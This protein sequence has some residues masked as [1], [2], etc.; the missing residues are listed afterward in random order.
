MCKYKH[1][2]N[3]AS[4]VKGCNLY[5]YD[6]HPGRSTKSAHSGNT[7]CDAVTLRREIAECI[8]KVG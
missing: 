6:M 8:Y 7:F 3:V 4:T 5:E 2:E 1:L